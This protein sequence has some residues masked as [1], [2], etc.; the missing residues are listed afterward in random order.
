MITAYE[1]RCD[2]REKSDVVRRNPI[3]LRPRRDNSRPP[4]VVSRRQAGGMQIVAC[5][6]ES[7]VK[8]YVE[9]QRTDGN[10]PRR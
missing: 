1:K 2:F 4:S 6:P 8:Y 5:V 3:A 10:A 7:D 9:R